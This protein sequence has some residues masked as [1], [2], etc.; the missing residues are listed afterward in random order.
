MQH[1]LLTIL[2]AFALLISTN[3]LCF[4]QNNS[5][6]STQKKQTAAIEKLKKKVEKIGIGG[7]TTVIKS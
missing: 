4:T 7:K 5:A 2:A 6:N 1:S 3:H